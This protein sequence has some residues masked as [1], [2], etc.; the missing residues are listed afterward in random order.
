MEKVTE[1]YIEMWYTHILKCVKEHFEA[2]GEMPP[3]IHALGTDG[4]NIVIPIFSMG[5]DSERDFIATAFK[6]F[7]QKKDLIAT[8][9]CSEM[10]ITQRAIEKDKPVTY[11]TYGRP[12][13]QPDRME[14]LGVSFETKSSIKQKFFEIKRDQPKPYLIPFLE[15]VEPEEI[16]GRFTNFLRNI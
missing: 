12:S 1:E 16:K 2:H 5:P 15:G 6:M 9:F 13:E 4:E 11:G 10:W 14:V 8:V 3:I 7:A